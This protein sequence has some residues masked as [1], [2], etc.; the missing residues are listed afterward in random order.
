V[1]H[2][3]RAYQNEKP[4]LRGGL[5]ITGFTPHKG[6]ILKAVVANQGFRGVAFEHLFLDGQR[7]HL[8]RY[9]NRDPQ[10]PIRGGWAYVA[11]ELT[12]K[13][14]D[15][16]GDNRRALTYSEA[17]DVERVPVE[18]LSPW[19]AC[20]PTG[21]TATAWSPIRALSIRPTTTTG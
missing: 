1:G 6:D 19:Q 12:E 2:A 4:I 11:G 7:Q 5:P 8:A 9:P 13:Y 17:D 15:R 20:R 3:Y 18:L 14:A 16:P 10:N 21:R